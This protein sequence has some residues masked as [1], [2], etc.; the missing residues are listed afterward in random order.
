MSLSKN[1]SY[2]MYKEVLFLHSFSMLMVAHLLREKFGIFK[3]VDPD[4]EIDFRIPAIPGGIVSNSLEFKTS[5]EVEKLSIKL[6]VTHKN[7]V[8]FVLADELPKLNI[9]DSLDNVLDDRLNPVYFP[10]KLTYGIYIRV[11]DALSD[12]ALIDLKKIA[13]SKHPDLYLSRK[14]MQPIGE[15]KHAVYYNVN[16]L[17]IKAWRSKASKQTDQETTLFKSCLEEYTDNHFDKN[18]LSDENDELYAKTHEKFR[19]SYIGVEKSYQFPSL[20]ELVKLLVDTT[21]KPKQS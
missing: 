17:M 16:K 1:V 19:Q 9:E 18:Q 20:K 10:Q 5:P 14:R 15:E 21:H 12:K 13:K 2:N 6:G 3:F 11:D 4:E 7:L 8:R